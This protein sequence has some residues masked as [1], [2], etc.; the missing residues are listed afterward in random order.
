[1]H[2]RTSG[3]G[4]L[5]SGQLEY[6][7]CIWQNLSFLDHPHLHA[8]F[9]HIV[10]Q[11]VLPYISTPLSLSRDPRRVRVRMFGYA[12]CSRASQVEC[13]MALF[14]LN[15]DLDTTAERCLQICIRSP[16]A[17]TCL[18]LGCAGL[19]SRARFMLNYIK[20]FYYTR[21]FLTCASSQ[22]VTKEVN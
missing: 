10:A 4:A 14:C 9:S 18:L 20:L 15:T 7:S 13:L 11:R 6:L 19:P 2:E 1:M 17:P 3:G 8:T 12:K 22:F 16:A 21:A 5:A